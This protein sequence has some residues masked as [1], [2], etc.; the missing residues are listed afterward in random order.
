MIRRILVFAGVIVATILFL[1]GQHWVKSIPS[2]IPEDIPFESASASLQELPARN[3]QIVKFVESKGA[4]IAPS[5]STAVCT[6]FVIQVIEEFTPLTREEKKAVRIITKEPLT[7]LIDQ[8][9]GVIKGVYTALTSGGKG[10]AVAA[11]DVKPGDFVQFWN[12]G[13]GFAASGHCG[14]VKEISPLKSLTL[15]SSHPITN[16]YGIHEFEWPD[17]SYFVRMK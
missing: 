8:D 7:H 4:S 15:Y 1:F 5:Y 14:I 9:A 6:E 16:G 10:F 17:K 13:F 11:D 3:I 2:A 12:T